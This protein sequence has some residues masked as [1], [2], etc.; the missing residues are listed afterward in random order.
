M[1]SPDFSMKESSYMGSDDDTTFS[2][3]ITR[4]YSIGFL[5]TDTELG[6]NQHF[7]SLLKNTCESFG[8]RLVVFEGQALNTPDL[9]AR[10]YNSIY[11]IISSHRIDALLVSSSG[12][13]LYVGAEGL[14]TFLCSFP[15][16]TITV[17]MKVE[18]IPSIKSDD[19]AAVTLLLNHLAEHKYKKIVWVSGTAKDVHSKDRLEVFKEKIITINPNFL[20]K[21]D[22]LYGD[23]S[24]RSGYETMALLHIRVG[25]T[26]DA[27]CFAN[28]E[29]ALGAMEYCNEYNIRVPEDVAITGIDNIEMSQT[30]T[31]GITTVSQNMQGMIEAAVS[32]LVNQ[33]DEIVEPSTMMKSDSKDSKY[34]HMHLNTDVLLN[35]EANSQ[36]DKEFRFTNEVFQEI[37][38]PKLHIRGSCG[39]ETHEL[40]T[41]NIFLKSLVNRNQLVGETIQT[42]DSVE[43]FDRLEMFLRGRGVS[44]CF[45]MSYEDLPEDMLCHNFEPPVFSR[46]LHGFVNGRRVAY[47]HVFQT[48][49]LLP[50]EIW[51][52]IR[53]RNILMKALFFQNEAFGYI[54]ASAEDKDKAYI[55]DLRHM[56]SVTIKG[57]KLINE[58]QQAQKRLEWALDAMRTVNTRLSDISLRDELTS[59]YNRR[60]FIQEASRYLHSNPKTFLLG[61]IDMNGL[62]MINDTYGHDDGDIAIRAVSDILRQSFRDHDIIAR[63]GGDEFAVLVVDVGEE[64]IQRLEDRFEEKC[65]QT[66]ASLQKPYRISFARGYIIGDASSDLETL[67]QLADTKMYEN[68]QKQK[69]RIASGEDMGILL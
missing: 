20:E 69:A 18:G 44:F 13:G 56:V 7:F 57:E 1:N 64:Q 45:I 19:S 9:N 35:P 40:P 11:K 60:G 42:F 47:E 27:I 55:N 48:A 26:L 14:K 29:M 62:K 53:T 30:V 17:G 51:S 67:M 61:F 41:Q 23:F 50:D 15:L 24:A 38:S 49:Q 10:C 12:L 59:L 43:L 52:M 28:D 8:V 22:V 68:K 46:M 34:G 25:N 63:V 39:C 4:P 58:R 16:P 31:P 54:V 66:T 6:F 36:M 5:V 65:E 33:I 3:Q 2:N 37:F 32:Y 21:T